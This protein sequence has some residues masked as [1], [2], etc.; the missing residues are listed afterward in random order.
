MNNFINFT[1]YSSIL[2]F[3][4]GC[5]LFLKKSNFF[6]FILIIVGITSIINHFHNDITN[7][8][9]SIDEWPIYRICDWVFVLILIVLI[10]IYHY[11]HYYFYFFSLIILYLFIFIILG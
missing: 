1:L 4:I 6:Y 2:I 8:D 11:K 10:F 5:F 9:Y 7:N 3:L